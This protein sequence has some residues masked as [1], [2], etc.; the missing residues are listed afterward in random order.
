LLAP[1]DRNAE[2]CGEIACIVNGYVDPCCAI[3]SRPPAAAPVPADHTDLPDHLDRA[4]IASGLGRIDTRGCGKQSPAH[5]D[6]NVSVKVSPA[7]AITGVTVRN[8]PDP[9]LDACVAAAVRQ[10]TFPAT[11]RGGSFGYVWRF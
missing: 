11:Q 2:A 3:W 10:G 6:V 8:S 5:G 7:G 9:A 4:A 1:P